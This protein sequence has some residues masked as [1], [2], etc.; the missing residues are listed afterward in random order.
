MKTEDTEDFDPL[1]TKLK[2]SKREIEAAEFL[3]NM[4]ENQRKWVR[5]V[6]NL[7]QSPEDIGIRIWQLLAE[8]RLHRIPRSTALLVVR[9]F[10]ETADLPI[11][12]RK[13]IAKAAGAYTD[14]PKAEYDEDE[15][16]PWGKPPKPL[17]KRND[18]QP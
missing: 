3:L 6:K 15:E 7:D 1:A 18:N 8:A 9:R 13:I 5:D 4:T 16:K 17:G 10:S 12:D 14:P 11:D 2:Y